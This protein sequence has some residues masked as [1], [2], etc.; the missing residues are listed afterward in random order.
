[1]KVEKVK[2]GGIIT[3]FREVYEH[4][5]SYVRA[6]LYWMVGSEP[7]D[8]LVQETFVKVWKSFDSF[9]GESH[10]KTWIYRIAINTAKD[11]LKKKG[12]YLSV[13]NEK[14]FLKAE[15]PRDLALADAI[16]KSILSLN[17]KHREVFVL[18]YK[19]EL[20]V[21]EVA[22]SLNLPQGTVKSRLH[23]GR[24]IFIKNLKKIGFSYE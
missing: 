16:E 17:L 23:K 18:Y 1:M 8:D 5:H 22:E 9:Q 3:S 2:E 4:Y 20:S 11:F 14:G 21:E 10:I 6:S 24:E 19:I 12:R 7:L 13:L 15:N